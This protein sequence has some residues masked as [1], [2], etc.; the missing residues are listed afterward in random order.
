M[1][2][3]KL[4]TACDVHRQ[5]AHLYD[6]HIL[7]VHTDDLHV[8]DVQVYDM[9]A[10]DMHVYNVQVYDVHAYDMPEYDVHEFLV[11]MHDVHMYA[12]HVYNMLVYE[13]RMQIELLA[14]VP[15][16]LDRKQPV[17]AI[18]GP[19]AATELAMLAT[20]QALSPLTLP[21]LPAL[22]SCTD[23]P[24]TPAGECAHH[25]TAGVSEDLVLATRHTAA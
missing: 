11:H 22:L 19:N 17:Y 3:T 7:N 23:N 14:G 21:C 12:V 18:H 16:Y 8:H 25:A 13:Y 20:L 1:F 2:C 9:H 5:C 6:V 4:L 24:H 15:S 10:Y